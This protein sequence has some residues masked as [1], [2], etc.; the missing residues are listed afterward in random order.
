[1][2]LHHR[3]KQGASDKI[4]L[5]NELISA[6]ISIFLIYSNL[7]LYTDRLYYLN[8]TEEDSW[9]DCPAIS[10]EGDVEMRTG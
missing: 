4:L 7:V 6:H 8:Q 3:C 9:V 5:E 10:F 1:M 2:K